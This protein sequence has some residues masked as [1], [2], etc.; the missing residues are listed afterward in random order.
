[1]YPNF[2]C[3]PDSPCPREI[4]FLPI[5]LSLP[6]KNSFHAGFVVLLLVNNTHTTGH[7]RPSIENFLVMLFLRFLHSPLGLSR[8]HDYATPL[9]KRMQH[10]QRHGQKQ[11]LM[12]KQDYILTKYE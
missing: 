4:K 12:T 7:G 8:M 1:M 11:L 6:E 3:L 2:L 10:Y 5:D 9:L